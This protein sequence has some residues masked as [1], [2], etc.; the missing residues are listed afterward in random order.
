MTRQYGESAAQA[1]A[2]FLKT[3]LPHSEIT[4]RDTQTGTVTAI[5]HAAR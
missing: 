2:I 1:A 4:V 5:K 3:R